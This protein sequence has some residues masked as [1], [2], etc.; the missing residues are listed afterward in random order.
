MWRDRL[1][2]ASFRGVPF[3]VDI[4]SRASGR[5]GQVFEFPKR[6]DPEDEDLGRRAPRVQVEGYC[7]GPDYDTQADDLETALNTEGGGALVLPFS[8]EM[9][10]RC[11]TYTRSERREQGGMATFNMAFAESPEQPVADR[12]PESTKAKLDEA[13]SG[14]TE[15]AKNRFPRS[16]QAGHA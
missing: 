1:R 6:D 14:V 7:I 5:R 10:M 2:P 9:R 8:D 13:I 11:E 12:V 3:K 4:A 16:G 15:Q